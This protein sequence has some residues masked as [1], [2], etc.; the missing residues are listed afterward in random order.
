MQELAAGLLVLGAGMYLVWYL[1]RVG[2]KRPLP[3]SCAGCL[4][5]QPPLVP[6]EGGENTP[7]C[8]TPGVG[9]SEDSFPHP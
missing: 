4:G 3:P 1:V 6:L 5:C 9:R 2:R 7:S 8:Q